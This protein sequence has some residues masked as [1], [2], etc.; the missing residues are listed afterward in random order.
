MGTET[1]IP[2]CSACNV[3]KP[4]LIFPGWFSVNIH[5]IEKRV[6]VKFRANSVPSGVVLGVENINQTRGFARTLEENAKVHP[7]RKSYHL[8]VRMSQN[9]DSL[10]T[11]KISL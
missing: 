7:V 5:G 1:P 9:D 4:L 2:P 6:Y 8:D 11:A 3:I 10:G